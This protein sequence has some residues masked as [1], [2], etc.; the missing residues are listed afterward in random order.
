[1]KASSF[2]DETSRAGL[3]VAELKRLA[4]LQRASAQLRAT[5]NRGAAGLREAREKVNGEKVNGDTYHL[6]PVTYHPLA[7]WMNFFAVVALLLFAAVALYGE[8]MP[9][10][11][12]CTTLIPVMLGAV[13]TALVLLV[14][15]VV[16][17]CRR[18]KPRGAVTRSEKEGGAL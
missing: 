3:P 5:V 6:S 8:R 16:A 14:L 15:V 2:C 9:F 11:F 17:D 13:V 7:R 12:V 4:A 10:D 18:G 1:M